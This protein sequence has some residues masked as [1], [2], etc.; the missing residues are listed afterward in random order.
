M[1]KINSNFQIGEFYTH[2]VD[3]EVR[4]IFVL[5]ELENI[6]NFK[7]ACTNMCARMGRNGFACRTRGKQKICWVN[8][9]RE[10]TEDEK[11]FYKKCVSAKGFFIE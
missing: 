2:M 6:K 5:S 11:E 4:D 10:S 9:M 1:K 7:M 3:D 8:Y